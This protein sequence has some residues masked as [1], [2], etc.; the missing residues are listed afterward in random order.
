MECQ[1]EKSPHLRHI[2]LYEY[3][4]G[5]S[6]YQATKNINAIYGKSFVARGTA[7]IWF[8]RFK[9]MNFD[10]DDRSRTGRPIEVNDERV[11]SL[12][13]KD[14]RLTTREIAEELGCDHST[15]VLR[16]NK[17]EY[18][19]RI[20]V[21]VPHKLNQYNKNIRSLICASLL[22]R[23]REAMRQHRPFLSLIITGD[24]K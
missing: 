11:V 2:L 1:V 10:M 20:G 18:V 23:H 21:W 9:N 14:P 13:D 5:V 8:N 7:Q 22:Q 24:E 17:L 3:N 6:A 15:V 16:L 4:H 12:L 19:Q